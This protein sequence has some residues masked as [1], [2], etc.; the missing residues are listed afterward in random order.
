MSGYFLFTLRSTLHPLPSSCRTFPECCGLLVSAWL[1][2]VGYPGGDKE[3]RDGK[4]Q[5]IGASPYSHFFRSGCLSLCGSSSQ[6]GS[7]CCGSSFHGQPWLWDV[8]IAT[9]SHY[10]SGPRSDAGF[11]LLQLSG[12]PQLP[13]SALLFSQPFYN[14]LPLLTFLLLHYLVLLLFSE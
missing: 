2:P 3:G 10:A 14:Q 7:L 13:H 6:L 12:L 1:H 5:C 8:G 11:P 4:S 9:C